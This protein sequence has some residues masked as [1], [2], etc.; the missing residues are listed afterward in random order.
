[1]GRELRRV[2]IDFKWPLGQIWK[3]FINPY[4]C[5]NCKSC[6]GSGLNKETKKIS[7]DWYSHL[8]TDGEQGWSKHL[9]DVEV[10]ALAKEGRL[11][12]LIPN[13]PHLDTKTNKWMAWIN[14]ENVEVPKPDYPTAEEVNIA[15]AKGLGHDSINRWICTEARAKHLGV[16]GP[17]E[18]CEDGVIW[19]SSE[20]KKLHDDWE[21]FGP[22]A[23]DGYQLWNTTTEGHPMTPVFA[24]LQ[25]LCGYL[26]IEDISIFGAERWTKEEWYKSLSGGA[27][28]YTE[29]N[30]VFF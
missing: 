26:E 19:Q 12:R 18:F 2:S 3:G 15:F 22:P 8:R 24:T 16:Y 30:N 23:G 11:D 1:M 10:E 28:Y 20:V 17:C 7:D 6:D 13:K 9:T 4:T 21:P 29:G 27:V 25:E 14:G 5:M